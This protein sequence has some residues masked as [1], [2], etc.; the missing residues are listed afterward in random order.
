[1]ERIDMLG[2][3]FLFRVARALRA[4]LGRKC[5]DGARLIFAARRYKV[6]IIHLLP[7]GDGWRFVSERRREVFTD[8]GLDGSPCSP[9]SATDMAHLFSVLHVGLIQ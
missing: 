4:Y 9:G 5:T 6:S 1:M 8:V 3:S 7:L 2:D